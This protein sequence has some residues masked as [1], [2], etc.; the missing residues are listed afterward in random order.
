M[1]EQVI[2]IA[3]DAAQFMRTRNFSIENKGMVGNDVTT[4]DKMMQ[5][6]IKEH[7]A[8][9]D[10]TIGFV[11]E[12]SVEQD[13]ASMRAWV[14]DPIDGTANFIRGLN[15]SVISI[16]LVEC[17]EAVLGVVYNPYQDEMFYAERGKGAYLNGKQIAVSGRDFCHGVYC[18]AFCLYRKEYATTCRQIMADVYEK[19]ED[20]RRMGTA[21]LEL[22]ALAAGRVELYF[23]MRLYP[24]DFAASVIIIKEAGGIIGTIERSETIRS[25]QYVSNIQNKNL[26]YNRPIPVIAAN[27]QKNYDELEKII[28]RYVPV[29]PYGD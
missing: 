19:C 5:E 11:G 27:N 20:F 13:Y 21:A 6:Y 12:E 26:V 9:L 25:L 4:A 14:V 16:G 28:K 15:A 8:E 1:I 18:T 7:L 2:K 22:T 17:G 29:V 10:G 24:W 3:R 23:E